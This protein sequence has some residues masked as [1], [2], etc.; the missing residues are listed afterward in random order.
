LAARVPQ[1]CGIERNDHR[2]RQ[3]G[4]TEPGLQALSG[5]LFI[6]CIVRRIGNQENNVTESRRRYRLGKGIAMAQTT[7]TNVPRLVT[8]LL[9]LLGCLVVAV[10][11]IFP[12]TEPIPLILIGSGVTVLALACFLFFSV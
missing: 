12:L 7:K 2:P 10:P 11:M 3:R 8:L 5:F 9:A 6:D 1:Q 4:V